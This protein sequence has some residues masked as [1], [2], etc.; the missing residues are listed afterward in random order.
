MS[1]MYFAGDGQELDAGGSKA[2][3]LLV[4]CSFNH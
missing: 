2:M 1:A 3:L 4:Q